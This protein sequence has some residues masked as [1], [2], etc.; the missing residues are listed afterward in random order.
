MKND[1]NS[2]EEL[3]EILRKNPII[4]PAC[5]RCAISRSTLYR[6]KSSDE[7]FAK[8]IEEAISEGR[9]LVT[10]LAESKLMSAIKNENLG[11]I[12]FWLKN[13]DARYSDKLE[14]KGHVT[15]ASYVLTPEQEISI[16]KAL[17]CSGVNNKGEQ[18]DKK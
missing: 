11:A 4:Q 5:D 3:I 10:E 7:Q 17:I 15:S 14:I 6:W 2:K 1:D 18:N 12:I 8:R 13:N 16:K 9:I